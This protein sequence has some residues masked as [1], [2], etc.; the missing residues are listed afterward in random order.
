MEKMAFLMRK[1]ALADPVRKDSGFNRRQQRE[2][3]KIR[4]TISVT[5]GFSC[6]NSLFQP[7]AGPSI[8]ERTMLDPTQSRGRQTRLLKSA[9]APKFDAIITGWSQHVY[10]LSAFRSFWLHESALILFVD[11][12]SVLIAAPKTPVSPAVDKVI[13][14][15]PSWMSTNRQEQPAAIAELV[16]KELS[17]ARVKRIAVDASAVSSQVLL[18]FEGESAAIDPILWHMRRQKDPDELVLIRKAYACVDA[19]FKRAR[20]IIEPGVEETR[21]F[22]ELNMAAVMEAGEPLTALLGNDFACG[23]GGGPARGGRFARAGEIYIIDPGPAYRGYFSDACRGF[24]VNRKP[25]NEQLKAHAAITESLK[26]V[27]KMARPG[28]RCR[29]IFDAVDQNM[30]QRL[31]KGMMHHLGH[32]VGLQPHEFPHLNP[33]WDDT[34][35][36]GEFFTAEPGAYGP[37]LAGGLRIENAY[38][39]KANGLENF[40][41]ATTDLA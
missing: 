38:L 34:L 5:P 31:G 4:L 7:E 36:E 10:Y 8:I 17:A 24:A 22:S 11:G 1:A 14:Y 37:H 27:E 40:V 2:H 39:V 13:E 29:E 16:Q 15:P 26:I 30:K 18:G 35:M 41:S 25:T 19:I 21:V 6:S 23:V 32:G 12:R 33:N 3:Q 28:V 20:E 9:D